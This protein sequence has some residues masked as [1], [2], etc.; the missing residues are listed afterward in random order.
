MNV[1]VPM[2]RFTPRREPVPGD[3]LDIHFIHVRSKHEMRCRRLS[4]TDDP[5]AVKVTIPAASA[6]LRTQRLIAS[7]RAIDRM[8][9]FAGVSAASG[10]GWGGP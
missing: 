6:S 4:R 2:P 1:A 3:A 7:M 9:L 10:D 8:R 5:N